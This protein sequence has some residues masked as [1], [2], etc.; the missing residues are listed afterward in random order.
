M[1]TSLHRDI[2]AQQDELATKSDLK[3]LAVNLGPPDPAM[4]L[5]EAACTSCH[6]KGKFTSA[7]GVSG[8]IPE[9]VERMAAQADAG[10]QE[11]DLPRIEAA[12]TLMRCAHC[13]SGEKLK[14]M[15]IL[16]P[17]E[18]WETILEMSRKPGATISPKDA[19]R[20]RDAYGL[21]WTWHMR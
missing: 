15:A 4:V 19:R 1:V 12:L 10:I 9:L 16:S 6:S 7:H 13:H 14:E 11:E 5:L 3:N 17:H 2:A 8:N 18:R 21:F 20:I